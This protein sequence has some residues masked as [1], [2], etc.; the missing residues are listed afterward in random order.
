LS[1]ARNDQKIEEGE[2]EYATVSLKIDV[3]VSVSPR[4]IWPRESRRKNKV[5]L[6]PLESIFDS[7]NHCHHT[8][9]KTNVGGIK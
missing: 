4:A 7:R 3:I 8:G 5:S 9:A 2:G 1:D 6:G